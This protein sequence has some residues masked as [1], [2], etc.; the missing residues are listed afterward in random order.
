M[1]SKIAKMVVVSCMD[2]RMVT[3]TVTMLNSNGYS[4]QYDLVSVAGSALSVGLENRRHLTSECR[5]QLSA[6]KETICSHVDLAGKL[7]GAKEVWFIDH[8]DCGAYAHYY[9]DETVSEE[10]QHRNILGRMPKYFPDIK[11]RTF[12]M[13][14]DG[15]ILELV[16]DIWIK[17]NIYNTDKQWINT[18]NNKIAKVID[19]SEGK[20]RYKYLDIDCEIISSRIVFEKMFCDVS[21][22]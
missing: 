19:C 13:G 22:I 8:E 10:K 15:I 16:N 4:G 7:H 14:L 17:S 12:W 11:V 3:E 6:W 1:K 5:C 2:L 18:Y 9:G 21:E 20:V